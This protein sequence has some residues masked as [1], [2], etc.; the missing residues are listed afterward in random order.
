MAADRLAYFADMKRACE[1]LISVDALLSPQASTRA[2]FDYLQ[3]IRW[4]RDARASGG[5]DFID[6]VA[7]VRDAVSNG[8]HK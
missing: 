7:A 1:W 5:V 4:E 3:L 2:H 8:E 6:L